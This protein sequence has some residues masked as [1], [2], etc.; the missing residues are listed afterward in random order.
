M[1]YEDKIPLKD[2]TDPKLCPKLC[3]SDLAAST[4][5]G[6]DVI[7][8]ELPWACPY[9]DMTHDSQVLWIG[10]FPF[11]VS[12]SVWRVMCLLQHD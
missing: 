10:H 5:Y 8:S 2:E 1:T 7:Y 11:V 4:S 3:R 6:G 9:S 12:S